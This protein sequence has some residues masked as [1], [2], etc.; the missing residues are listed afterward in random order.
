[1][2]LLKTGPTA[3]CF[4]ATA[5]LAIGVSVGD[6]S[7][8]GTPQDLQVIKENGVVRIVTG[9]NSP[10]LA[11]AFGDVPFK[12]YIRELFTPGGVQVL[13]DS[14]SDHK[15]HHAL[16]FATS[17][18]GTDFWSET[19][20]CGRQST[21]DTV[22]TKA[23]SLS[24]RAHRTSRASFR[25]EVQWQRPDRIPVLNE[26]RI[27][28]AYGGDDLPMTLITWQS[29][30][31]PPRA[32]GVVTLTG[33]HYVGL[34]MRFVTSMDNGGRFITPE[35]KQGDVVRGTERVTPAPWCAYAAS[36]Q[37]KPVTVAL[38][39]HPG[40][41]RHPAPMFTMTAPFAYLSATLNLWK[42]PF[43]IQAGNPVVLRYGVAAWDGQVDPTAVAKAY[44]RWL[45]LEGLPGDR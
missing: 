42:T 32:E 15:H 38:F 14:P 5:F 36:A 6:S 16:M 31:E 4:V 24:D 43:V 19:P 41:S 40:N 28:V 45:Q 25:F 18:D 1:M 2:N 34:G 37:G 11:Y 23:E 33:A 12:P 22:E 7:E 3:R 10:L 39:D 35:G 8:Q 21:S 44:E 17:A 13:R 30:L 20:T 29:R 9:R 27:I 26:K